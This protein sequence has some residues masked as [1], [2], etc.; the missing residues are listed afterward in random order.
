LKELIN[1]HS[2]VDRSLRWVLFLWPLSKYICCFLL[3]IYCRLTVSE[4][5]Y[6]LDMIY[7]SLYYAFPSHFFLSSFTDFSHTFLT[8]MLVKQLNECIS[9]LLNNL[10]NV[11]KS[12][13]FPRK[14]VYY[15]I[16]QGKGGH[17][18]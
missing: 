14:F 18:L 1:E 6:L 4:S 13:F 3:V 7:R 12:S 2:N 5:K 17:W 9:A 16:K 10:W 11:A 8:F 15:G